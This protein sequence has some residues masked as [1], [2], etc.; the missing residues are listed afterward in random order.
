M[1]CVNWLNF[2]ILCVNNVLSVMKL[3]GIFSLNIIYCFYLKPFKHQFVKN[4]L[5]NLPTT[6]LPPIFENHFPQAREWGGIILQNIYPW[7]IPCFCCLVFMLQLENFIHKLFFFL[8]SFRSRVLKNLHVL[9]HTFK[10][11][12]NFLSN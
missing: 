8:Q 6:P 12:L 2:D 9:T 7:N 5:F 1:L 3:S 10:L 11:L 4:V